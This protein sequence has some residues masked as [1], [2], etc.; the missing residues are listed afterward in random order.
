M[1]VPTKPVGG[2]SIESAWGAVV[3]DTVVEQDIQ[4]GVATAPATASGV[5]NSGVTV[6]F[7]RSF[8]VGSIPVV[9]AMSN[10]SAPFVIHAYNVTASGCSMVSTN[11]T[12]GTGS[13]GARP[14]M[15]VAIGLRT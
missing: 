7:P 2:A 12:A 13:L 1:A 3:H 8:R 10:S 6:T 4:F 9:V 14:M 15:W 5:D 11:R